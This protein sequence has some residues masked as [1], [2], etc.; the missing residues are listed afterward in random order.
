MSPSVRVLS[1]S[2]VAQLNEKACAATFRFEEELQGVFAQAA[3]NKKRR[4]H[5]Q[6]IVNLLG[7]DAIGL[8]A[9]GKPCDLIEREIAGSTNWA[10]NKDTTPLTSMALKTA[11]N[12]NSTDLKH[13]V[14]NLLDDHP[15]LEAWAK[16]PNRTPED[17]AGVSYAGFSPS[18]A[19]TTLIVNAAALD[20]QDQ[21]PPGKKID[22]NSLTF[23]TLESVVKGVRGE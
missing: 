8:D 23:S 17:M 11:V 14:V 15:Q 21:M 22:P 19:A 6:K 12:S 13:K 3:Q 2:D 10:L 20:M 16:N 7:G 4:E 5:T 9:Y 1:T 18:E